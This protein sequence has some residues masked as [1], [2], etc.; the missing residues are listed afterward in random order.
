MRRAFLRFAFA[1]GLA[2]SAMAAGTTAYNVTSTT[3]HSLGAAP[4][5]IQVIGDP[6]T[7][8]VSDSTPTTGT[9]GMTIV[10]TS[11]PIV[12]NAADGSSNVY[13]A[14]FA[15]N[16]SE[17]IYSP[18]Y[19]SGGGGGGGAVTAAA[20]S[21]ST[22]FSPDIGVFGSMRP[23]SGQ[24]YGQRHQSSRRYR[25]RR[26]RASRDPS[27]HHLYW[28]RRADR[29]LEL[30]STCF[31]GRFRGLS[32]R[33]SRGRFDRH[34]GNGS[35][36]GQHRAQV[37][38]SSGSGGGGGGG[39]VTAA[40]N[41]YSTGFSP[42]IGVFGSMVPYQGSGTA[43]VINLLG[44]IEADARGPLATQASTI[45]IGGVGQI[46]TWNFNQPASSV[47]SGAY[48]SGALADGA[49]VTLGTEADAAN[50]ATG[51]TLM[52]AVRQLDADVVTLN[53]TAAGSVAAG[54]ANIGK[55][56]MLG[57][58]GGTLDTAAGSAASTLFGVQGGGA[59]AVPMSIIPPTVTTGNLVTGTTAAMT[60]TTST[61]VVA[62]VSSKRLYITRIKCNNSSASTN[63]LV[64]IQDGSGGTTL[65]TLAA[66]DA[67]G[68][69]VDTNPLP[70]F[71][72]TSGNGLYAAN[73]TNGASVICSANGFSG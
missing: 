63:T 56:D 9:V 14:K 8:V 12:I 51:H 20:N 2:S 54:S 49:I 32:L 29:N 44:G 69:E 39:A 52:A 16:N 18:V 33:R 72:T 27:W 17:I 62:L 7:I 38:L 37:T 68:G 47:A 30:Q 4:V 53:T 13:V 65:D 59:A 55:F 64:S 26:A 1:F 58:A 23:V 61:Q 25:S 57:N 45:S 34:A 31:V 35:G 41:S 5:Q 10:R 70:L 21:Y 73:V 11:T 67:Y 46:G 42:D 43:N 15:G 60:G 50:I 48:L 71:W 40:A 28:R 24:R 6:V 19:G 3:F 22:G 66:G 36:R